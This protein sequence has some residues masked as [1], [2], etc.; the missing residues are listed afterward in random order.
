MADQ[1]LKK[2]PK[3]AAELADEE[4][5]HTGGGRFNRRLLMT[6]SVFAVVVGI[7]AVEGIR[8]AGVKATSVATPQPA[9]DG[10]DAARDKA[11]VEELA[12]GGR[13]PQAAPSPA[14]PATV[15]TIPSRQV[16]V[17][18]RPKAPGRYA[19]WAED[20]YMRALEAPQMVGAFHG[21]GTLEIGSARAGQGGAVSSTSGAASS[22]DPNVT[23]HPPASPYTVMTGSVIPAVMV[24][25]INSDLPG[26]ILAQVSQSVF[27]S[28]SGKTLLIP[29]GS[30]LVGVYRNASSY[31]QQRVQIAFQRLIF[32]DTSSMDLPQMPGGDQGG[33]AGFTDQVNNHYLATFGTAALTSLISAGQMVGQMAAFGGGGTYGSLGYYQ[34]NQWAM[35]G[36][37]AGSAGSA[38]LGGLGQQM[39]GQGMNR[40]P[41]IEVRPGYEFNVMVTEDLVFPGPYKG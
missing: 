21:G 28:A 29:Q 11:E 4:H 35:A 12:A 23:L 8:S 25:G 2:D 17:E 32:P 3:L 38:Q 6:F 40:P 14:L 33:Y 39:L 30:R 7:A 5:D 31:G 9:D 18:H 16:Q 20:K 37:T 22:S 15:M 27:D 24:S 19:Q 1:E 41:T 13:R 10:A 26:P 34:P 36:E